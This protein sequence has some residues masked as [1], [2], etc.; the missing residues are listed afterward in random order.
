MVRRVWIWLFILAVAISA[1]AQ[2]VPANQIPPTCQCSQGIAARYPSGSSSSEVYVANC[3]CEPQYC[4]VSWNTSSK[5]A[6]VTLACSPGL[7]PEQTSNC[8]DF[9]N[10][11]KQ[12]ISD[13]KAFGGFVITPAKQP[14]YAKTEIRGATIVDSAGNEVAYPPNSLQFNPVTSLKLPSVASRIEFT[15]TAGM[16]GGFR[17]SW[18]NGKGEFRQTL[19]GQND[20]EHK[21]LTRSFSDPAG[22]DA[23]TIES[24]EH[25]YLKICTFRDAAGAQADRA[26]SVPTSKN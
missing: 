11:E 20:V 14:A 25:G 7:A 16:G 9:T 2:T 13:R 10:M 18:L 23:I 19:D 26:R 4:A 8:V 17:V 6:G 5:Y 24:V 15:Y 1:S 3:W 22:F 21:V 12:Q